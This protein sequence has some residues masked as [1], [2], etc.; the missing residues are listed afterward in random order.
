M[1]PAAIARVQY[2]SYSD[3]QVVAV[4]AAIV[5]SAAPPGANSRLCAHIRL[6]TAQVL[7]RANKNNEDPFVTVE[8]SLCRELGLPVSE[9]Q[10]QSLQIVNGGDSES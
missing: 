9:S 7:R 4:G 2:R 3:C 1:V 5:S 10:V 6:A 8:Q